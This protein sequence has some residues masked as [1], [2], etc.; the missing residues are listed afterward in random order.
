MLDVKLLGFELVKELYSND[1]DFSH[2]YS[3]SGSTMQGKFY[4]LDGFL[5]YLNKL[6]IPNCSIHSLLV[7]EVQGGG[8]IGHF[9]VSKTLVILQVHF[10]WPRMKRNVERMVAKCITCHKSKFKF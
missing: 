10:H 4:I 8:L 9:G 1:P 2:I 6:Y 3:S 5:F 7:R